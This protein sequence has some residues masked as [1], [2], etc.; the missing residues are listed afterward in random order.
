MLVRRLSRGGEKVE[1]I[2]A[3]APKSLSAD[4]RTVATGTVLLV[5]HCPLSAVPVAPKFCSEN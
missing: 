3:G 5:K 1:Y 4:L 2:D